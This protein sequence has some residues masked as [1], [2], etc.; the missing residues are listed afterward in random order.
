MRPGQWLLFLGA[1]ILLHAIAFWTWEWQEKHRS[2]EAIAPPEFEPIEFVTV[3]NT[4][5][6]PPPDTERIAAANA[7]ESGRTEREPLPPTAAAVAPTAPAPQV[8]ASS[9]SSSSAPPV[10]PPPPEP[11]APTPLPVER[12]SRPEPQPST[13]QRPEPTSP[14]VAGVPAT[15]RQPE[16]VTQP[17]PEPTPEP[18]LEPQ[19][20]LRSRPT[21]RPEP[22][23]SARPAVPTPVPEPSRQQPQ[24]APERPAPQ[25]ARPPVPTAPA[26]ELPAAALTPQPLVREAPAATSPAT[27]SPATPLAETPESSNGLLGGPIARSLDEEGTSEFFNPPAGSDRAA[28][29]PQSTAARQDIDLGPYLSELQRRVRRNWQPSSPRRDRQTLIQFQIARNG[30]IRNLRVVQTS[31][32]PIVDRETLEAIERAAPF[33]PLPSGFHQE[34]LN[35]NFSFNIHITENDRPSLRLGPS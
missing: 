33:P 16:R 25:I 4:T 8:S 28:E 35:V 29:T 1:S 15:L 26:T 6:D 2:S 18:A 27:E 22:L 7:V 21:V 34:A 14:P 9:P 32:S 5:T 23:P 12:T 10:S 17:Q 3:P 31:G 13:R 19:P 11:P 20:P 24:P 30:Q